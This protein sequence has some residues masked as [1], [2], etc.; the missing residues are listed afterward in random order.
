MRERVEMLGGHFEIESR[1]GL[2]TTIQV[3]VPPD[4]TR[5]GED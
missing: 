3:Q 1:P 2:G 5:R 4:K